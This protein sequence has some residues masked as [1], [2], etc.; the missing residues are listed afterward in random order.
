MSPWL[1]HTRVCDTLHNSQ[2]NPEPFL[3]RTDATVRAPLGEMASSP[4]V[5]SLPSP[6]ARIRTLDASLP[7][8]GRG[9]QG[10]IS[11]LRLAVP[12][13]HIAAKAWGSP[14]SRRVL[15]LHGWLDNANSFDRLIPLLPK[16][17]YY[18]AMDF[19]GHGLSSHYRPGVQ[20]HVEGFMSEIRRAMAALKW[21]R[22]SIMGHSFG[23]IIGG[24]FSCTF[25]E[26]VDKLVLLE[27]SLAAL[28]TNELE[29]LLDY[30]RKRIEITLQ[31]EEASGKPPRVYSQEEILQKLLQANTHVSEESA[32]II[33]QRGT[34]PV[35]TGV[36]LN[37]DQRLTLPEF[38]TEFLGKDKVVPFTKKLQAH[39]LF[40]RASQGCNDVRKEN[41]RKEEPMGFMLKTL[42]SVLKEQFQYVE[43][44]GNHYVHINQPDL[45]A[46]VISSF[47]ESDCPQAQE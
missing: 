7:Q 12:W 44:P 18:V 25:P 39:L 37:R 29:N 24:M 43:V 41:V 22:C 16:D 4:A 17:F 28:D 40:I 33:L 35:A 36:V 23:G 5:P 3:E 32:K 1:G 21:N 20:Y 11:E 45:V 46:A 30:R 19:G 26:M 34:S 9:Q 31:Q 10:L 42:K 27:S 8:P 38:Y 13:G 6:S 15:C 14:G 47:L 2:R